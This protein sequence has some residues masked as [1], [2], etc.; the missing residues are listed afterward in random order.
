MQLELVTG[1]AKRRGD[2]PEFVGS[3][4]SAAQEHVHYEEGELA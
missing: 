4:S 2:D 1:K 3:F